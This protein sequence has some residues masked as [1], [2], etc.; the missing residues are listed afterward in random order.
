MVL[1]VEEAAKLLRIGRAAAYA[2]VRSGEIPSV[3]VGR[4]I[5]VPYS[6]L[7]AKLKSPPHD[8]R[9]KEAVQPSSPA[10]GQPSGTRSPR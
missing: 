8:G 5:R 7:V 10:D 3:R 2:A 9:P 6:A 1:T 4:F